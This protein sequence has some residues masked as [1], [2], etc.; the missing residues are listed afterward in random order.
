MYGA[1]S[2]QFFAAMVWLSIWSNRYYWLL[3]VGSGCGPGGR[4]E[5]SGNGT[6]RRLLSIGCVD[7]AAAREHRYDF[8]IAGNIRGQRTRQQGADRS[9]MRPVLF[10]ELVFDPHCSSLASGPMNSSEA[11]VR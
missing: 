5:L 3:I 8:F 6:S 2:S 7:S 1:F 11:A 4:R 9:W 10:M